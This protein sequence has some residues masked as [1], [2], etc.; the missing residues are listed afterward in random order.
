MITLKYT[1][2]NVLPCSVVE[3]LTVSEC[4]MKMTN[5]INEQ[6]EQIADLQT[7]VKTLENKENA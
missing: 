2:T 7:R 1:G 3:E 6:Q 5:I 4:L